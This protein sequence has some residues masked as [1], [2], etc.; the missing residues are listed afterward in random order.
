MPGTAIDG[1]MQAA[2][3]LIRRGRRET[4]YARVLSLMGAEAASPTHRNAV[5]RVLEG[6][7]ITVRDQPTN[8]TPSARPAPVHGRSNTSKMLEASGFTTGVRECELCDSAKI[9]IGTQRERRLLKEATILASAK[10]IHR[11][12][13]F[14]LKY[15]CTLDEREVL[16]DANCIAAFHRRVVDFMA[17]STMR[18]HAAGIIDCLKLGLEYPDFLL[19]RKC[20]KK[21]IRHALKCWQNMKRDYDRR[22]RQ[23]QRRKI[24]SCQTDINVEIYEI[25]LALGTLKSNFDKRMKKL[26]EMPNGAR[27]VPKELIDD[28]KIVNCV[29]ATYLL[30]QAV[31]L[32]TALNITITEVLTATKCQGYYV[33]RIVTNKTSNTRGAATVAL[34]SSQYVHLK[35]LAEIRAKMNMG[36]SVIVTATGRPAN[37]VLDPLSKMINRNLTFNHI[38]VF[39]ESHSHLTENAQEKQKTISSYLCH[40]GEVASKYYRFKADQVVLNES[41]TVQN[42]L[43]QAAALEVVR[44]QNL[45][46]MS[47][48]GNELLFLTFLTI[49]NSCVEN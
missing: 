29:V 33:L 32:S 35:Q 7:S 27:F 49:F 28:W 4:S 30:L 45:L 15:L 20:S 34:K 11:Y 23:E 8:S 5:I 31:R 22:E 26:T 42:V 19:F 44:K 13:S 18:N 40:T 17:A 43:Y 41:F 1:Y 12:I 48:Q 6:F 21:R 39:V 25:I 46:P 47:V 24:N 38:R 9:Y 36:N 3:G 10:A 16:L 2:E 37:L 14:G